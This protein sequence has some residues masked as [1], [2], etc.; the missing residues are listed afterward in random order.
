MN[1]FIYD[2][3]TEDLTGQ[4]RLGWS[5]Y[6]GVQG[7]PYRW[8]HVNLT[9]YTLSDGGDVEPPQMPHD[10]AGSVDSPQSIVQSAGDGVPLGGNEAAPE[11]SRVTVAEGPSVADGTLTATLQ[12]G[13]AGGTVHA[14]AIGPDGV[15]ADQAVEIEAGETAEVSIDVGDAG[16][17]SLKL[18][19]S[20]LTEDGAVDAVVTP[21]Q[22]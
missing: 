3:D 7:D 12:A 22:G 8:G 21:V 2:S 20:F 19:Y 13:D 4:T 6:G 5:T 15:I 9:G 1:I 16:P 17:A 14:F 18:A 11:D 10:V